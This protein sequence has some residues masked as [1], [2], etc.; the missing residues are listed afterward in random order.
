[1]KK[2]QNITS[3][4]LENKFSGLKEILD[5]LGMIESGAI[6][7]KPV[8]A[9]REKKNLVSN[10]LL[11]DV[12]SR[13]DQSSKTEKIDWNRTIRNAKQSYNH[14]DKDY[15][16]RGDKKG[17]RFVRTKDNLD[18]PNDLKH[19]VA[20]QTYI[21]LQL[22]LMNS[23]GSLHWDT[24][25]QLLQAD[26]PLAMISFLGVCIEQK[27]GVHFRYKKDRLQKINEYRE[28]VPGKI[29]FRDGHWMLLGYE[30]KTKSWKL[31]LLHSILDLSPELDSLLQYRVFSN[32]PDVE[33]KDFF[34]NTFSIAVLDDVIPVE[35]QI[36]VP[37]EHVASIKK[38]RKEGKWE[39]KENFYLWKVTSYD[40]EEIFS[41]IFKWNGILSI[42]GPE[43]LK[44]KFK[45]QLTNLLDKI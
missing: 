37:Q 26:Y 41:Y 7:F 27:I 2:G 6:Y 30:N 15:F 42:Y 23:R 45:T 32:R 24:L 34:K 17:T 3:N 20:Y 13:I 40:P 10:T 12:L 44:E 1:L 22:A 31:F 25:H 28:I 14:N 38:R 39:K 18:F 33:P 11:Q 9:L 19:S 4:P 35:I 8:K 29:I 16:I 5:V 21:I 36:K 43:E